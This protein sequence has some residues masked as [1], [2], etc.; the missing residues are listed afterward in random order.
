MID[1]IGPTCRPNRKPHGFQKWRSL[2]FMHWAVPVSE[3]RPLVPEILEL[4]LFE[5]EAFVGVV[6]F[7]MEAVRPSWCPARLGFNFLETNVRTYVVCGNQPGVYFLSLEAASRIAVWAAR[8]FWSLP[9]HFAEMSTRQDGDV[10][11]YMSERINS[12][13]KHRVSYT[14]GESLGASEPSSRQFFFLERYLL[15]AERRHQMLVGQVHHTPYPVRAAEI[16]E[17]QDGLMEAAGLPGSD[18][19]PAFAHYSDGVDV[20]VFNL[21]A[22]TP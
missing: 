4:D 17:V 22:T 11:H 21:R 3:L 1:R 9:Y 5:G 14:V 7:A 8:R 19:L 18:E 16:V 12:H 10:T 2:L 6:P 20:E 13:A 15:F